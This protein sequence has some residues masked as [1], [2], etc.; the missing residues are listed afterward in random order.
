MR[1][2]SGKSLVSFCQTLIRGYGP[3]LNRVLPNVDQFLSQFWPRLVNILTK[4]WPKSSFFLTSGEGLTNEYSTVRKC[5]YVFLL[6][7]TVKN[8]ISFWKIFDESRKL[9]VFYRNF[10]D[11]KSSSLN[12][13]YLPWKWLYKKVVNHKNEDRAMF[14]IYKTFVLVLKTL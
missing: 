1:K 6:L 8:L 7:H 11:F 10:D 5:Y 4:A 9:L 2:F 3:K 13:L 12:K 14:D